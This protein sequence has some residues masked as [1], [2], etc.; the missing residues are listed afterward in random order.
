MYISLNRHDSFRQEMCRCPTSSSAV[1]PA[2]SH[3]GYHE[4]QPTSEFS[5]FLEYVKREVPQYHRSS[6]NLGGTVGSVFATA[7]IGVQ[8]MPQ[9]GAMIQPQ[10]GEPSLLL[11]LIPTAFAVAGATITVMM[12]CC[13]CQAWQ[14]PLGACSRQKLQTAH[15]HCL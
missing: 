12:H 9:P 2:V 5:K 6:A 4:Q 1:W 15:N 10:G 13:H 11:T 7:A 14:R 8:Y 3:L